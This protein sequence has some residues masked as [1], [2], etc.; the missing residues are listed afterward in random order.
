MVITY[1]AL[2]SISWLL[3]LPE[4]EAITMSI[5]ILELPAAT[6]GKVVVTV[7][8]DG[9]VIGAFGSLIEAQKYFR[10]P[11]YR[12]SLRGLTLP[13]RT[14]RTRMV[15]RY[16]DDGSHAVFAVLDENGD[17]AYYIVTGPGGYIWPGSFSLN[18]A[19]DLAATLA[20]E[21][22][23]PSPPSEPSPD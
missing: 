15:K 5:E 11:K 20:A 16:G 8:V 3:P 13:R 9:Q 7:R 10:D 17:D 6:P 14:S 18:D 2:I 19:M 23:A 1:K 21:Y 12:P 4:R 22:D